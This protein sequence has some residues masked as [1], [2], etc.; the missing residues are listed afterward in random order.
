MLT[1]YKANGTYHVHTGVS[2]F[3]DSIPRGPAAST[4]IVNNDDTHAPRVNEAFNGLFRSMTL[5]FLADGKSVY[6]R[7]PVF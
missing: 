7:A 4:Y 2:G 3:V 5:R 6:W 1:I